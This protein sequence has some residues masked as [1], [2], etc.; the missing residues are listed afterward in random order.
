MFIG[1]IRFMVPSFIH[2]VYILCRLSSWLREKGPCEAGILP[3]GS[4]LIAGDPVAV[5]RALA[6]EH[7]PSLPSCAP[8]AVLG[9]YVGVPRWQE[10]RDYQRRLQEAVDYLRGH[11]SIKHFTVAPRVQS[12]EDDD[13]FFR[14]IRLL[15]SCG[16]GLEFGRRGD[17]AL[18]ASSCPGE[19]RGSCGLP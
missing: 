10:S 12:Y 6:S 14:A 13:A 3:C 4:F 16:A 15:R 9:V 7:E 19:I 2:R 5:I 11:P 1:F 17:L 8:K 18:F